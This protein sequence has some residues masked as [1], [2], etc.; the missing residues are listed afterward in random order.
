[1]V[2]KS[3]SCSKTLAIDVQK[4]EWNTWWFCAC[5]VLEQLPAR[6]IT[7]LQCSFKSPPIP[8]PQGTA[9][10][11]KHF[12]CPTFSGM[13]LYPI[14]YY[15]PLIPTLSRGGGRGGVGVFIDSCIS[16]TLIVAHLWAPTPFKIK[17]GIGLYF[18][19]LHILFHSVRSLCFPNVTNWTKLNVQLIKFNRTQSNSIIW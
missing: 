2:T 5:F 13:I 10:F 4:T 14:H 18:L 15:S 6:I 16:S 8:H 17:T 1:M 19:C 11:T 9:K 3:S 7:T 12:Q